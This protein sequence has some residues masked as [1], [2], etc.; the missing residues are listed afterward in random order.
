MP[1]KRRPKRLP[2]RFRIHNLDSATFAEVLIRVSKDAIRLSK[3]AIQDSRYH[4]EICRGLVFKKQQ[5]VILPEY[6]TGEKNFPLC[7][8][9]ARVG[10]R[11]VEVTLN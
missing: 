3:D 8:F 2:S 10:Y 4:G 1:R 6:V 7:V 11:P 5:Y 9:A